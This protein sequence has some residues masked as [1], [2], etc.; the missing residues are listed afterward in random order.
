ME[1]LKKFNK[2]F[3]SF[4]PFELVIEPDGTERLIKK[5]EF[6]QIRGIDRRLISAWRKKYK[7]YISNTI[8]YNG[9][10]GK[11]IWKLSCAFYG[12]LLC[13]T[14]WE[15][16]CSFMTLAG[17]SSQNVPNNHPF[18]KTAV[19]ACYRVI[20]HVYATMDVVVKDDDNTRRKRIKIADDYIETNEPVL[21]EKLLK[22][23]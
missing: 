19:A 7:N 17:Y 1:L 5:C 8:V 2:V 18:N 12:A 11:N 3:L 9:D 22:N 4:I 23:K 20:D 14:T 13:E 6:W 15:G 16:A 10:N 21:I